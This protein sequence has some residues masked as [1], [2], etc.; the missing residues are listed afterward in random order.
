M[1]V[2]YLFS[3]KSPNERRA[4]GFD[5]SLAQEFQTTSGQ[6]AQSISAYAVDCPNNDGG[7]VIENSVLSGKTT[8]PL[9]VSA[10]IGQGNAGVCYH[11]RFTVTTN[12]GNIIQRTVL[13]PVQGH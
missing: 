8:N 7:L 1:S 12:L 2:P 5:F 4:F 3:V 6:V 13:L 11:V 10:Y 9:I